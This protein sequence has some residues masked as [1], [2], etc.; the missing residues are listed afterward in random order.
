MFFYM[1]YRQNDF[2]TWIQQKQWILL[3]I[4]L[5]CLAE[6]NHR[7][8]DKFTL[9][10]SKNVSPWYHRTLKPAGFII[11]NIL[12]LPSSECVWNKN[13]FHD[14]HQY[15]YTSIKKANTVNA[16]QGVQCKLRNEFKTLSVLAIIRL[17]CKKKIYGQICLRSISH[18]FKKCDRDG[19]IMHEAIKLV[20]FSL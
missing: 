8:R 20:W 13:L 14:R 11:T 2:V 5:I 6:S 17:N 10:A 4:K 16:K 7:L 1:N 18:R 19:M 3:G 15:Y 9:A 12:S